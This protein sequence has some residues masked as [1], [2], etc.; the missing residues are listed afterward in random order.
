MRQSVTRLTQGVAYWVSNSPRVRELG[1]RDLAGVWTNRGVTGTKAVRRGLL[2]LGGGPVG[3][4]PG[5][6]RLGALHKTLGR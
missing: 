2:I 5:G 1:L 6:G 4:E 3:A